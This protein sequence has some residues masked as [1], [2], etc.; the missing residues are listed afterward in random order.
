MGGTAADLAAIAGAA[1]SN[2]KQ[3]VRD[4]IMLLLGSLL[5]VCVVC[6]VKSEEFAE[7]PSGS[8]FSKETRG[9]EPTEVRCG[10]LWTYEG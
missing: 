2:S 5:L 4:I 8:G 7:V 9:N 10:Y 1:S 3:T 6:C